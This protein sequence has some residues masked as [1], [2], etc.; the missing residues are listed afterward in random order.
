MVSVN[1]VRQMNKLLN[2]RK[3][4][5]AMLA[6]VRSEKYRGICIFKEQ[7]DFYGYYGKRN[8]DFRIEK[9]IMLDMIDRQIERNTQQ[10]LEIGVEPPLDE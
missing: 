3:T 6:D 1:T 10:L 8:P 4:L 9:G 2:D 5:R 7:E